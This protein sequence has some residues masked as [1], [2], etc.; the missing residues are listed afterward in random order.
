MYSI[1]YEWP[2]R[3]AAMSLTFMGCFFLAVLRVPKDDD[4]QIST[5]V[6]PNMMSTAHIRPSL[7]QPGSGA[8]GSPCAPYCN[9]E[10]SSRTSLATSA[11]PPTLTT[12]SS[13]T[14]ILRKAGHYEDD[15][16][17]PFA[18]YFANLRHMNNGTSGAVEVVGLKPTR[19]SLLYILNLAQ[20]WVHTITI[21]SPNRKVIA[22]RI[23]VITGLICFL[24]SLLC[25]V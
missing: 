16:V 14:S 7:F 11:S 1:L 20:E 10:E 13:S 3:R 25:M 17:V 21:Y 15:L 6:E 2:L 4:P 8:Y 23:V 12:A 18:T 24:L 9:E 22:L 5:T 19:G